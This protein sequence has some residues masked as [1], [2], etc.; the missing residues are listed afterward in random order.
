MAQ[1]IGV[2]TK[3]SAGVIFAKASV[4]ISFDLTFTEQWN[5]STTEKF[6]FTVYAFI[7]II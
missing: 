1:K 5:T 2:S 7:V 3:L 4:T 6:Q